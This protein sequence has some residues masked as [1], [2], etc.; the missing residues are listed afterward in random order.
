MA[1]E[2]LNVAKRAAG[3]VHEA[4][5]PGDERPASRVG[6][7]A[8]EAD[9]TTLWSEDFSNGQRFDGRLTVRNPFV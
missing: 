4:G 6:R 2:L 1:G 3:L 9:C 5:R 7:A 8:L